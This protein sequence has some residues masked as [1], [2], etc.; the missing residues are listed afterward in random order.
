MVT[1][2]VTMPINSP[3]RIMYGTLCGAL[4][5]LIRIFGA[6]PEGM[7]FAILLSN[8]LAPVIDY[9]AW[10][11]QKITVKKIIWIGAIVAAA[12]IIICLA[13]GLGGRA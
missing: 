11:S 10:S 12:A 1:D 6:L 4:V 8:M 2:P 3:G 5:V 7:A 9:H 13:L